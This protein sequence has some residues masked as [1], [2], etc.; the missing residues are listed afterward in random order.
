MSQGWRSWGISA[1]KQIECDR[2]TGVNWNILITSLAFLRDARSL[3]I[4]AIKWFSLS[5]VSDYCAESRLHSHL[6]CDEKE[7]ERP[8]PVIILSWL[9]KKGEDVLSKH[10]QHIATNLTSARLHE[11]EFEKFY[12]TSMARN[13]VY[14]R[15]RN[16]IT[17]HTI[18]E[19]GEEVMPRIRTKHYVATYCGDDLEPVESESMNL[20]D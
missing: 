12:F 5:Y 15:S 8:C 9:C 19:K 20:T 7:D 11:R 18:G 2:L 6:S 13:N 14:G 16:P 10:A 3:S 4:L 1:D 17:W